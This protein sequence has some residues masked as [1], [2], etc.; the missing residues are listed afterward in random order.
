MHLHGSPRPPAGAALWTPALA[1][2]YGEPPNAV[3]TSSNRLTNDEARRITKLIARLHEPVE[4]EQDRNKARS[5]RKPRPLRVKPVTIGDLIREEKLLEVSSAA[6]PAG[7]QSRARVR[8]S[9]CEGG[10]APD[11]SLDRGCCIWPPMN[12]DISTGT[13]RL[14]S[15]RAR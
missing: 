14:I 15:S 5:R 13:H 2:V 11:H 1:H 9:T 6:V 8:R 7:Q 10:S 12:V 3:A 4:L